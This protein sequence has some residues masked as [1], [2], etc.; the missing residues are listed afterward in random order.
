M[1]RVTAFIALALVVGASAPASTIDEGS[2]SGRRVEAAIKPA[3]E[4]SNPASLAGKQRYIVALADGSDVTKVVRDH[5]RRFG[6]ETTFVYR[7]VFDGY[8]GFIDAAQVPAIEAEPGVLFV[9]A[10]ED[11]RPPGTQAGPRPEQPPQTPSFTIGRINAD[12]SS[13]RSG[14][15]KGLVNVN[16]A[17]LDS[18]VQPDHPDLNVVNGYNCLDGNVNNWADPMYHGTAVAGFAAA[19]DN[20]I[21]E[22]GIAP[23]ARISAVRVLDVDGFGFNSEV[24]CGM[25]WVAG[26]RLDS[27]TG[28][29]IDIANMSLGGPA[30]DD[31]NC[32]RTIHKSE[33]LAICGL[34]AHGV[35][36]VV[37]AGNES[38]DLKDIG[39]GS[40]NEVLTVTAMA[41]RDAA[42]GGLGGQFTCDPAEYDDTPATFTNFATL[43]EDR[44]HVV[45]APGVCTG[46]LSIDSGYGAG[47]GTS[48]SAPIVSGLV[49]LCIASG[50]CAGLT[51]AQVVSK[52]VA[53]A[54]AYNLA[55]PTYG[56]Q[57]DPL[58]PIDGRYFG[59]LVN[60]GMY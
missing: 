53:D 52:V 7:N 60:A 4:P 15:G 17:V 57:G 45:A 18:G 48:F 31:G 46:G 5:G 24:I 9:E 2:A 40:Y 13:A 38:S 29:D 28:N 26:T 49:G 22:V 56:Y 47:S 23:G 6:V 54:E 8:A 34:V 1:R 30:T 3:G 21:G 43:A 36:V 16:I 12:D 19:R 58:R 51:P 50:P 11:D 10:D 33:H 41:D 27:N 14:D 25:E 59:Y 20:K 35:V 44:S 37:S 42:P 32:G 55:N 39:P